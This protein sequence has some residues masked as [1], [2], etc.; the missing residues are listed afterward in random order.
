MS[1][2][3]V[4]NEAYNIYAMM[5]DEYGCDHMGGWR[6]ANEFLNAHVALEDISIGTKEV[7]LE[8]IKETYEL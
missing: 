3:E 4:W 2:T 1:I 6:E 8:D 7:I 5:R